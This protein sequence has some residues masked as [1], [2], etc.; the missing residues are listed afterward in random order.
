[1][2]WLCLNKAVSGAHSLNGLGGSL[3][4]TLS[5]TTA[6][7]SL[8]LLLLL[9]TAHNACNKMLE[10]LTAISLVANIVQFIDFA[11]K[12]VSEATEAYKSANGLSKENCDIETVTN[13]LVIISK[14]LTASN[15]A[16]SADPALDNLCV[17][18]VAVS[19]ELLSALAKLKAGKD[20]AKWRSVRKALRSVWIKDKISS[21]EPRLGGFRDEVNLRIVVSLRC[22]NVSSNRLTIS[23]RRVVRERLEALALQQ[24]DCFASIDNQL[25]TLVDAIRSGQDVFTASLESRTQS[26]KLTIAESEARSRADHAEARDEII[27]VVD[28]TV[29]KN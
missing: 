29:Q 1:V 28:D 18:C 5:A 13:D 3:S 12:I 20:S 8:S 22:A 19:Q 15:A 24:S 10:P 4:I 7:R 16:T 27:A 25:K 9:R 6:P 17:G 26:L 21:L 11:C 2:Q 23:L 14:S